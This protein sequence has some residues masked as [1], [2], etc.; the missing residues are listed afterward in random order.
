MDKEK[1]RRTRISYSLIGNTRRLGVK[2]SE[3]TKLKKSLALKGR[4]PWNKGKYSSEKTRKKMSLTRKGKVYPWMYRVPSDETK[5]KLSETSTQAWNDASKRKRM[6]DRC[7]WNNVSADKGQIELLSKWN[8]LGFHF[9][10]NYRVKTE[11][12]LFYLDGYDPIYKVVLEYDSKYHKKLSQQKKDFI[13]QNK[14]IDI[15]KPKKFW[16]YNSITKQF[17]NVLK[18]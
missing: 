6:L 14:V 4:E 12:D 13:R 10:P 17:R 16:R 2:D 18:E 9:E 15:L 8:T 7:R 5:K 3:E 1:T 11:N